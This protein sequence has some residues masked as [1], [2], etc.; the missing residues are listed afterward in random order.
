[1]C[2]A[3]AASPICLLS[4]HAVAM[5]PCAKAPK[6]A[7]KCPKDGH[8]QLNTQY[9]IDETGSV[10]QKYHKVNL[11]VTEHQAYSKTGGE[12][13]DPAPFGPETKYFDSRYG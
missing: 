12:G 11:W 2:I 10:V 6:G 4:F 13:T 9:A 7:A 1:M 3:T 5:Q 8:Y